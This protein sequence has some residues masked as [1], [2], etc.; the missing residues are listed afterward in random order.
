MQLNLEGNSGGEVF[1]KLRNIDLNDYIMADQDPE[2]SGK[3]G[4]CAVIAIFNLVLQI[5]NSFSQNGL[6]RKIDFI[7]LHGNANTNPGFEVDRQNLLGAIGCDRYS[8]FNGYM[9]FSTHDLM[10]EHLMGMMRDNDR[11]NFWNNIFRITDR[12]GLKVS[13]SDYNSRLSNLDALKC[14]T[15]KNFIV[16]EYGKR[17]NVGN[18]IDKSMIVEMIKNSNL[19]KK[20]LCMIERVLKNAEF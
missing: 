1:P 16:D 11:E 10:I 19:T 3:I 7:E 13:V 5:K 4:C 17:K 12:Y 6:F 14:P 18:Q 8:D 20:S 2:R 9:I 15:M